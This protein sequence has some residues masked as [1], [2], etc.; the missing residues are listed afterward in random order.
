MKICT[1]CGETKDISEFYLQK[2]GYRVSR[3]DPCRK[4]KANDSAR[5]YRYGISA[6][7]YELMLEA[8]NHSCAVCGVPFGSGINK[9]NID[10][11]HECCPGSVTCGKCVRGI[12]CSI[13][14]T[15]AGAVENNLDHLNAM[16]EY[17]TFHLKRQGYEGELSDAV[18]PRP[19]GVKFTKLRKSEV[20]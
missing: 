6:E 8:Q 9:A 16:F 19:E 17:L 4:K 15:M 13:C 5:K 20:N 12:I 14:N 3:C 7:Q 10:H 18:W 1:L 2:N 11:D